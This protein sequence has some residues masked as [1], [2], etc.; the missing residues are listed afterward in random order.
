MGTTELAGRRS[1]LSAGVPGAAPR[2]PS[3]TWNTH[4]WSADELAVRA[5]WSQEVTREWAWGGSTGCGVRVCRWT[6]ESTRPTL[7]WARCRAPSLS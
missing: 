6:A 1:A 4:G 3:L 5:D 7:T 2:R